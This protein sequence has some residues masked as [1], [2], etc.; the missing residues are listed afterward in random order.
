MEIKCFQHIKV[1]SGTLGLHAADRNSVGYTH[2]PYA[3]R[4][5]RRK[6]AR[7]RACACAVVVL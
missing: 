7:A 6:R 5:T 2:T 4:F 1:R 3:A